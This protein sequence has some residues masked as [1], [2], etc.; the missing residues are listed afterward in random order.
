VKMSGSAVVAVRKRDERTGA[1]GRGASNI[2]GGGGGKW[3][4]RK[5]VPKNTIY[6]KL[7]FGK[8]GGRRRSQQNIEE[9]KKGGLFVKEGK[10]ETGDYWE[11]WGQRE[12]ARGPTL[13]RG[14]SEK[15]WL[16]NCDYLWE[17]RKETGINK[18]GMQSRTQLEAQITHIPVR[19]KH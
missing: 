19:S 10:R 1:P 7:L 11:R 8:R 9:A 2:T 17:D 6:E 16:Q 18:E 13:N 3:G 15:Q 5:A 4:E 14:K 12:L